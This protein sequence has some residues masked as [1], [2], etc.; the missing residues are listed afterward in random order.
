MRYVRNPSKLSTDQQQQGHVVAPSHDTKSSLSCGF[1]KRLISKDS[2]G[3]ECC[4]QEDRARAHSYRLMTD[5]TKCFNLLATT[6]TKHDS[7]MSMETTTSDVET[8]FSSSRQRPMTLFDRDESVC[9]SFHANNLSTASSTVNES[10]AVGIPK[11][12]ETINTKLAMKELSMMFSSP[13]MG[14]GGSDAEGA[15]LLEKEE[16]DTTA[17]FS[18]VDGLVDDDAANNSI[19]VAGEEHDENDGHAR[20][21]NARNVDNEDFHQDALQMLEGERDASVGGRATEQAAASGFSI[22]CDDDDDY[23]GDT[24]GAPFEIYQ[25]PAR[26]SVGDTATFSVLA[27]ALQTSSPAASAPAGFE[28]FNDDD[29]RSSGGDTATFSL[30]GDV[31]KPAPPVASAAAFHIHEDETDCEGDTATFSVFGN[32]MS[33]RND[34]KAAAGFSIY[35]D[36]GN[37]VSVQRTETACVNI[38]SFNLSLY[39]FVKERLMTLKCTNR[40]KQPVRQSLVIFPASLLMNT[41]LRFVEPQSRHENKGNPMKLF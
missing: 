9:S 34:G 24:T 39:C 32:A 2:S 17:T 6:T 19:L 38:T 23:E 3:Q 12:E 21:P 18:L 11:E 37:K 25:D 29:K 5:A 20:N 30:L 26:E 40:R 35:A 15:I 28:I 7:T 41:T 10:H 14:L 16:G 33:A 31:L 36:D 13:A 8:S 4:F 27:S 22:Y 1:D